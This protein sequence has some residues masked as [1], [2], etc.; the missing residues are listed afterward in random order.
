MGTT[1]IAIPNNYKQLS[2]ITK[3]AYLYACLALDY[4]ICIESGVNFNS[5]TI[6]LD[7][8]SD[9]SDT[10]YNIYINLSSLKSYLPNKFI[11]ESFFK[12]FDT[13]AVNKGLMF[14][15]IN[16]S[17]N[18][19]I[20]LDVASSF[21]MLDDFISR[22]DFNPK[23]PQEILDGS[24]KIICDYLAFVNCISPTA[25]SDAELLPLQNT[26][27]YVCNPNFVKLNP[28][29]RELKIE[30]Y[31][32]LTDTKITRK[33]LT[34]LKAK[35]LE[36]GIVG[37]GGASS[38]FYYFT[39]ML[40]KYYK[41]KDL[42]KSI[43][44]WEGDEIDKSN[45]PRIPLDYITPTRDTLYTN[46]GYFIPL[47][48]KLR[49]LTHHMKEEVSKHICCIPNFLTELS[50]T[51]DIELPRVFI[52]APNLVTRQQFN[53]STYRFYG[54]FH[55]NDEVLLWTNPNTQNSLAYETYG[56]IDLTHYFLNMFKGTVQLLIKLIEDDENTFVKDDLFFRYN[57]KQATENINSENYIIF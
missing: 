25:T 28:L 8:G 9:S 30:D 23:Y 11:D 14:N 5:N 45:L 49:L 50:E 42:F 3:K 19:I 44:V 48:S 29:L 21:T 37:L 10:E 33:T 13:I 46:N 56:K 39:E 57:S 47:K 24:A 34:D 32:K 1:F 26:N 7:Y 12:Q 17:S 31:F 52:G 2:T 43:T 35:R 4:P 20:H 53:K 40:C 55:Q 6:Q 15:S 16:T 54:I 51:N 36:I 27:T 38:C 18:S 22:Y 41:I